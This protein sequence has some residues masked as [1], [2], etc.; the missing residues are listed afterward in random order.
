MQ[1]EN[2]V[3]KR[4]NEFTFL[5]KLKTN[6]IPAIERMILK[7]EEHLKFLQDAKM[8]YINYATIDDMIGTSNLYLQHFKQRL[9]EYQTY[10]DTHMGTFFPDM[11]Y[12]K[13]QYKEQFLKC[14]D[15]KEGISGSNLWKN[16]SSPIKYDVCD[17]SG[18][19]F[20]D[21]D[22]VFC[23]YVSNITKHF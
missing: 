4:T 9:I 6:F 10:V 11:F 1:V 2:I 7:E 13:E 18:E 8:K 14:I 12:V 5:I 21:E 17:Y 3:R 20:L 16:Y 15:V 23:V 19:E 22:L